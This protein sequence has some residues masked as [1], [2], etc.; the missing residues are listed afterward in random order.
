VPAGGIIKLASR[1][2]RVGSIL[3]IE[4]GEEFPADMIVLATSNI[5]SSCYE[6]TSALDGEAV[7]KLR[8][9]S[10]L[11]MHHNTAEQIGELRGAVTLK[12]PTAALHSFEGRITIKSD[13][14]TSGIP[15][16][17]GVKQLVLRGSKLANTDWVYA[18][19]VY[20]GAQTKMM[21]NR[22]PTRFKFTKFERQLNRLVIML[23]I[24]NALLCVVAAIVFSTSDIKWSSQYD[25]D[26]RSFVGWIYAFLTQYILFSFTIPLSL[27]VTIEIVKVGQAAFMEWDSQMRWISPVDGKEHGMQC[28]ASA[29]NEELGMV[30][31]STSLLFL[32]HSFHLPVIMSVHY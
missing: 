10:T 15:A 13:A 23:F 22:N 8:V 25:L 31:Y 11:T 17:L 5:D 30:Y 24:F 32:L 27:Y 14:P 1:D 26:D 3:K 4:K 9:A 6:N 18:M 12:A 16:P 19:V 7:P 2:V 21:L 20:T 29:L 28:K